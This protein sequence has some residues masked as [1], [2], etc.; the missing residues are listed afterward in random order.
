MNRARRKTR[1]TAAE[2]HAAAVVAGAGAEAIYK[3]VG[4]RVMASDQA[5]SR[6]TLV[7][8]DDSANA[9]DRPNSRRCLFCLFQELLRCMGL[10]VVEAAGEAEAACAQLCRDARR[11]RF[12]AWE[13]RTQEGLVYAAVTEDMDVLTSLGSDFH[14]PT[15]RGSVWTACWMS[16]SGLEALVRSSTLGLKHG[17]RVLRNLFDVEGSR[18]RQP[19]PAYEIAPRAHVSHVSP[20]FTP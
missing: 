14:L 8:K 1:E 11:K 16:F 20:L 3:A 12:S 17:P 19:K 6:S 15:F 4:R 5:A 10:P 9:K 2:E 13:A 7:T 18:A